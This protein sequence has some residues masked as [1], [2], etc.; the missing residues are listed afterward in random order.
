MLYF[1]G[2]RNT[3]IFP[4]YHTHSSFSSDCNTDINDIIASAKNK[5]MNSICITDHYDMDFPVSPDEPDMDFNLDDVVYY[6]SMK[7]LSE[8]HSSD[9]DLRI[10]I[11]LGVT[12]E[13]CTKLTEYAKS[14]P[15]YDF[16]IASSHLVDN[17]DP[18][19]GVFFE[20]K[21]DVDAYTRY[22]E[23]IL[24]NVKNFKNYNVYGHLDY[25]MR[26]GK[27]KAD[28][29]IITDYYD[30]FKEIFDTIV[31]DGKGIEI[32]TGG[33]YKGLSFP[34]PHGDILQM[35][36]DAG[37]EIITIGSDAH[38]PEYIGYGFGVARDLLLSKGFKY[39]CTFS[40]QK[41]QFHSIY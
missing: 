38:T 8:S 34:H 5:G 7:R 10:G 14:R 35:Y 19:N 4:D 32:N 37:G 12:K 18:Y 33:L 3:M 27:N 40:K 30:I 17:M 1:Y 15:Q 29:F 13:N 11:E 6:D 21:T 36:K 16:F 23:T 24:Y 22:F 26:Y 20:G 2:D 39:Y 25:I 28:N 41:P 9:F 31:Y